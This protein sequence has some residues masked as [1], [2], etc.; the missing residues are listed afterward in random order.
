ML[1]TLSFL[2]AINIAASLQCPKSWVEFQ[3][4]CFWVSQDVV[5]W[6]SVSASC[7]QAFPLS[8]PAS[9]HSQGENAALATLLNGQR[10]WIGL[11]RAGDGNFS[12]SDGSQLN[13][14]YWDQGEPY[15][16]GDCAIINYNT[17]TGEWGS[18]NCHEEHV[19]TCEQPAL[20]ICPAG[21]SQFGDMCYVY[22]STHIA[23]NEQTHACL[24]QHPDA[25]PVSIHSAAQNAFLFSLSDGPGPWIGLRR[26]S[27]G[28]DYKWYDDSGLNFTNWVSPPDQDSAFYVDM[29]LADGTWRLDDY[30]S[31]TLPF[32]CQIQL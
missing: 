12:W 15:K 24:Q 23:G 1:F 29:S 31:F 4:S 8:Q 5:P 28:I 7:H 9:L 14:S 16:G 6:P 19:F 18:V 21:W 3:N 30:D 11:S 32:Y 10:A 17:V 2:V 26:T 20:K 13:F 22:S 25:E 27:A